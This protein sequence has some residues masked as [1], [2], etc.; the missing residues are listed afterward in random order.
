M[1][2][3]FRQESSASFTA[4]QYLSIYFYENALARTLFRSVY[5]RIFEPGRNVSLLCRSTRIIVYIAVFLDVGN[6]V[7]IYCEDIGTSLFAKPISSAEILVYP[8]FHD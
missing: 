4:I 2:G 5:N 7:F 8:D 3:N 6:P 1:G